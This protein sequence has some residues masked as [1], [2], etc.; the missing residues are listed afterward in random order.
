MNV[1]LR[2][3]LGNAGLG[4]TTGLTDELQGSRVTRGLQNPALC[5]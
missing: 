1:M 5:F 4:S 3:R 2:V